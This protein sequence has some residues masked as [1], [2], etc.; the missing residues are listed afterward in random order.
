M[1]VIVENQGVINQTWLYKQQ[2]G[3][4]HLKT[5]FFCLKFLN[6]KECLSFFNM[7]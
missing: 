6:E 1:Y 4:E 5:I 7:N 3:S 2:P